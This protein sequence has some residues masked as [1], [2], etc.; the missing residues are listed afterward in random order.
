MKRMFD[1]ASSFNGAIGNWDTSS[2]KEMNVAFANASSFDQDISDW[3]VSSVTGFGLL[4]NGATAL[5]D[6]NKGLIHESFSTNPNWMHGWSDLTSDRTAPQLVL[7]GEAELIHEAGTLFID[8]GATWSDDRDGSGE[9]DSQTSFD[10]GTP[11]VYSISY[12]FS[13]ATGNPAQPVSRTIYVIDLTP[14]ALTLTGEAIVRIEAGTDYLDGG[15][16]W[17]DAVDGNG[18]LLA[19]GEVKSLVPGLYVL[20]YDYTDEAGN[21]SETITRT[22]MVKDTTPPVISLNGSAEVTIEAGTE[23]QDEGASWSDLVDGTGTVDAKGT[24]KHRVPGVYSL[25][26]RKTDQAGNRSERVTRTVTVVNDDPDSL[27]LSANKVEENLP[28]GRAVGRFSWSDPNDPEGRGEYT[29]QIINEEAK[30][31]FKIDDNHTLLTRVPLDYESNS[32]HSVVIR[33]ADAYG[34]TL[35]QSFAI[36]VIDAFLPIVYTEDPVM[37]GARHL[38]AA[39]QVMDEGGSTGVSVRGFLVSSFAE[40]KLEDTGTIR[41]ISGKGPGAY[42]Q[43]VNGLQPNKQY[44]VRAYATNAEGTAYGSS[45]RIESMAYELAPGWSNA[46]KANFGEDWWSSP[47]FGMFHLQDDSGWIHHLSMGWAY[48]MPASGGGVWLWTEATGWAWTDK[49]IYPFLH[50][51]DSQSW[52]YFYGK[53]KDQI[54]FFRYSDSRWMVKP[55]IS[56][57]N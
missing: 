21:Q 44:Y 47:W 31:L 50:S 22:V 28:K 33:V 5:S 48:A 9:V 1:G 13:D 53:S 10:S 15:A 32:S 37:V 19:R 11:G 2:V 12:E 6:E 46:K 39:G 54:L 24:V 36:E 52:L 26:Y 8:P 25:T 38:V 27:A 16:T 30:A 35:E 14:P 40:V 49:G 7:I 18:T 20:R 3:N 43:R 29:I 57:N 55:R 17:T 41:V 23:Y 4:F 42:T 34:G 56:E 51:H 45:L